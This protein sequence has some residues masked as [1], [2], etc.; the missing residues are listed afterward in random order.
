MEYERNWYRPQIYR[1]MKNEQKMQKTNLLSLP[2][3]IDERSFSLSASE[4]HWLYAFN[5]L[6]QENNAVKSYW[7]YKIRLWE[8]EQWND[9]IC[10]YYW[11]LLTVL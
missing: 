1:E 11:Y 4:E 10:L 5:K 2:Y 3:L 8:S 6:R 7:Q 9:F